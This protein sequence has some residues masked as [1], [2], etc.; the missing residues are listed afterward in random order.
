MNTGFGSIEPDNYQRELTQL[1]V[2]I[3]AGETTVP[4]PIPLAEAKET[5]ADEDSPRERAVIIL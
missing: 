1:V 3:A 2:A 4:H 5:W